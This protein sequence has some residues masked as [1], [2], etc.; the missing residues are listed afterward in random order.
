MKTLYFVRHGRTLFNQLFKVQ[1]ISDTPLLAEG[2]Q[3][4]IDLGKQFKQEDIKFDAVFSSDLGRARQTT[5]LLIANSA[6]PQLTFVESEDFREVSFGMFEGI[7]N[8]EMWSRV[9]KFSGIDNL[10]AE[11][12]DN[13]RIQALASIKQMDEF[14]LA[15]SYD[16]VKKRINRVLKQ[17]T[18]SDATAVLAVSHGLFIDCILYSLFGDQ[19]TLNG[20]PNTSVTK[21]TYDEQEKTFQVDY[22]GRETDF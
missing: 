3:K 5:R 2:K 19:I 9:R 10:R 21:I 11:S 4:A 16:D 17:M 22:I 20:I 8:E 15:E 18:N 1:G 13:L 14:H 6:N 7:L 12:P